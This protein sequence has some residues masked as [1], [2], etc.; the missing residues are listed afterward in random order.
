MP[1]HLRSAPHVVKL[2]ER[3]FNWIAIVDE[4]GFEALRLKKQSVTRFGVDHPFRIT[5]ASGFM[6]SLALAVPVSVS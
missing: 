6:R 2:Q 4:Q 5:S 3:F 1:P